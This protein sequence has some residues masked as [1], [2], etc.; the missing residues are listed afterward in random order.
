MN[1]RV[2][3]TLKTRDSIVWITLINKGYIEFAKNFIMSIKKN[4]CEFDNS[5][6]FSSFVIF[7]TDQESYDEFKNEYNCVLFLS[8]S[9]SLPSEIQQWETKGYKEIVF[10]KLDVISCTLKNTVADYVGFIDM[11]IVLFSNPTKLIEQYISQYPD[12]SIFAQ[13]DEVLMNGMNTCSDRTYCPS[14]CTGMIVFKNDPFLYDTFDYNLATDSQH[15][16][17]DQDYLLKKIQDKN[18]KYLTIDRNVCING[19][20]PSLKDTR[21]IVPEGACTVH[22]NYLYN[23][24]KKD[25]MILQGMWYC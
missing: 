20:Y 10:K 11:D 19:C 17:G 13:C 16:Y 1:C 7:C 14:I 18:V 3:R 4:C 22:F 12:V 5:S 15:Y 8:S 9:S 24:M 23:Y 6:F 25:K 2:L 21:I